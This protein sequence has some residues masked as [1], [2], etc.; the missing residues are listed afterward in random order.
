LLCCV[1]GLLALPSAGLAAFRPSGVVSDSY[2]HLDVAAGTMSVR[3]EATVQ[4][5]IGKDASILYLYAMPA[6]KD[7]AVSRDNQALQVKVTPLNDKLGLPS[8]VAVT[9]P[10][11]LKAGAI[12]DFIMSYTVGTQNSDY[13]HIEPGVAEAVFVSQGVGSF[14]FIDVPTSAEN[15][16]DPGCFPTADQPKDVKGAGYQRWVCG[17]ATRATFGQDIASV[18]KACSNLDDRCRQQ[19]IKAPLSAF[20]QSITDTSLRG[21]LEADVAL[22]Q[23]SVHLTF[24]FF[25]HDE[26]WAQQQFAV[27]QAA[28]PKLEAAFGF[29]FAF[30]TMS[31][32]QSHHIEI[33]GAAGV[34]FWSGGDVLV[35]PVDEFSSE[36]TVHELAHQWA[37]SQNLTSSWLAEGLAEYGMRTVAPALAI[38]P[39]DRRWQSFPYKAAPLSQFENGWDINGSNPDFWY[40]KAGAFWFAY[41]QAIGGP[42]TMRA[43]LS[44]T[45]PDA[46]NAPFD[47]RWFM[48]AGERASGVNLDALFL[49]WVWDPAVATAQITERRAA[50]DL[51][52]AMDARAA[53]M[54]LSGTPADIQ[55]NLDA[56]IFTG[57]AGQVTNGATVLDA[58]ATVLKATTDAGLAPPD[59]VAKS[60]GTA[61]L[62][63]TRGVIEDQRLA[64]T[65][66]SGSA[67]KLTAEPEGSPALLK[68]ADAKQKFAEGRFDAAKQLAANAV[69]TA[70]NEVAAG[71][72]ITIAKAKQAEFKPSFL[73]KVGLLFSD[74]D[75]DL[76]EAQRAYDS[77]DPNRAVSLSKA[78]YAAWDGADGR[79]LQMLAVLTGVMC[80][81]S[82][83]VWYLLRRLDPPSTPF[84]GR[85]SA[86]PA[87]RHNIGDPEERRP[88]W[89]DWENTP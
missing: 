82:G 65:A 57:I 9:L 4:N 34:A 83:L 36:V 19:V 42:D 52:K 68:L 12:A 58:Y 24:R 73:S 50:H 79:G 61:P 33:G 59:A 35:T 72:M 32:R 55:E 67:A 45:S 71:K 17:E 6:A 2:Y 56:W 5:Q 31:L 63:R 7:V 70:F 13:A 40:G 86:G 81:L 87:G 60:W 78:A 84:G 25:R 20:A 85:K 41:Q 39:Y 76:A 10:K 49:G 18:R 44:Q 14:V 37:G 88:S 51:V 43:V 11:P 75:G 8:L 89:R 66:I 54:G 48:D 47:G 77:G 74:P 3:V 30:D 1:L 27:A 29:P 38:T 62:A 80:G 46:K 21:L 22:S 15:Y 26:A 53:A 23:K 16:L 69:T 28:L 64:V